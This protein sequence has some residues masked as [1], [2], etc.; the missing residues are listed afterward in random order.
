MSES[1]NAVQLYARTQQEN[2]R[3][4]EALDAAGANTPKV[5][6]CNLQAAGY[7]FKNGK[8]A[9]FT[10]NGEGVNCYTTDIPSEQQELEYELQHRH[11]NLGRYVGE[12][13]P[14]IEPM[15]VLKAR[16][17]AE[18]E[19][20]QKVAL[21]PTKDAGTYIQ[22]PLKVATTS[23]IK[24]GAAGSMSEGQAAVTK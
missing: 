19:A 23:S 3:K 8:R 17:F 18:F 15:E 11:P 16:F 21:D 24:A 5:Y 6:T 12:V 4:Q 1:L 20:A 2:I 14:L 10:P 22:A 9:Q 7:V 13:K